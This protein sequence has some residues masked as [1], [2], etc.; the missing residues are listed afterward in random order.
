MEIRN[1][2]R[3]ETCYYHFL[4]ISVSFLGPLRILFIV[5]Q[6]LFSG[7][8]FPFCFKGY[9]SPERNVIDLII[10]GISVNFGKSIN[11]EATNTHHVGGGPLTILIESVEKLRSASS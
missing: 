11:K 5:I 2:Q 9:K 3:W 7:T 4:S 8:F 6:E 10:I 1:W